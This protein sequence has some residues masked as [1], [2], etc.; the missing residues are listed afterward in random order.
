MK[1]KILWFTNTPS[2]ASKEFGNQTFGGGWISSLELLLNETELFELGICFFYNGSTYKRI[3]NGSVVYYGVPI[4][5]G[6]GFSRIISRHFASLKDEDPNHI[7]EKIIEDFKPDLIHIFGTEGGYSQILIDKSD[8][9][10]ISLQGLLG[11][12]TNSYFPPGFSISKV[13]FKSSLG[14]I[15]RGLTPIHDYR[16]LKKKAKREVKVIKN[17]KYFSGRTDFDR[18]Y[19]TMLNPQVHYFHCDEL[20]R[21]EFYLN[22][23]GAPSEIETNQNIIVGSTI[24]TNLYKG[25]DLIYEVLGLIDKHNITWK[26]FGI[27]ENDVFIRIIMRVLKIRNIEQRIQFCGQLNSTDL[28]EQL[29]TCHFF[30]HPS[31]ADNSPNSVCEAMLLGMPVLSS[32]VGGIKTLIKNEESGFLFNSHDKFELA[33]LLVHL[34]RNYEKAK[35]AGII[36]RETALK[37]HSP[38]SVISDLIESYN[39]ILGQNKDTK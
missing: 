30:V 7:I 25:L 34:I 24:S 19:I 18:N 1:R 33:G 22:Q 9:A 11:P 21:K 6:N 16:C 5:S 3:V 4:K 12:I 15:I 36:A 2:N 27:S 39:Y 26:I 35:N 20:M 23:W 38:D 10:I 37:R 8:K 14:A 28:I 31:Y 32:S 13:L 17:W 29:K